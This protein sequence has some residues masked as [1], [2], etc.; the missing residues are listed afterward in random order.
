MVLGVCVTSTDFTEVNIPSKTPDILEWIRK[1]N[2]NPTIQFQG[3]IHDSLSDRWITVFA[4][5]SDDDVENINPHVLP[6]PLDEETFTG[7]IFI[8]AT[9]N[10][11]QDD[12][13]RS[14][15]EY[16]SLTT[17]EYK[18][19][20]THWDIMETDDEN[21]EEPEDEEIEED[22]IAEDAP[23]QLQVRLKP[24]VVNTRNVYVSNPLRE[25]VLENFKEY[26][27]CAEELECETLNYVVTLCKNEGIDVDW[28]NRV[29]WGT[30][31][32]K[33]ISIYQTLKSNWSKQLNENE[34]DCKTFIGLPA[35]EVCPERWKESLDKIIE[36]DKKLYSANIAASIVLFCS[37]CKK[38]SRCDYYQMQTR[39]AD[40]PMTTFV[41]CLDCGKKWKF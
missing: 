31:R 20:C 21:E 6:S 39:S 17:E 37:R 13:Q 36:N 35:E 14:A 38:K 9:N 19:I 5:I 32:S 12:Y 11:N 33:A 26:V 34:V 29:F 8:F 28:G 40:E 22:E 23:R 1:K 7:S 15:S 3:K 18:T 25:K 10:E 27:T 24:M 30:Y 2:K 41:T 16:V 4:R